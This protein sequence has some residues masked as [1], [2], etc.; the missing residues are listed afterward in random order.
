[1]SCRAVPHRPRI[2]INEAE[3]RIVLIPSVD[4]ERN[5]SGI[6]EQLWDRRVGSP[7]TN[8]RSQGRK[9]FRNRITVKVVLSKC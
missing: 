4:D 1:M 3:P 5:A 2:P 7:I 8:R 6:T 9:F